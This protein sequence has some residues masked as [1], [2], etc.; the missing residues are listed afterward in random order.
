MT[1]KYTR[2][3]ATPRDGEP[4]QK[5]CAV[6]PRAHLFRETTPERAVCTACG[7]V[8]HSDDAINGVVFYV[9]DKL[10]LGTPKCNLKE[11]AK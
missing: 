3:K 9:G 11:I 5:H 10:R 4:K 7:C 8:R 1:R 2:H 6:A